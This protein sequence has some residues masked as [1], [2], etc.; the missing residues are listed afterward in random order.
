MGDRHVPRYEREN[1]GGAAG[2]KYQLD[3]EIVLSKDAGFFGDPRR[4][5]IGA[6]GAVA[7]I[8]AGSLSAG[9][10]TKRQVKRQRSD[11]YIKYLF[12]FYRRAP[13]D[14]FLAEFYRTK[15][16]ETRKP[17][18][19]EPG[20]SSRQTQLR[21]GIAASTYSAYFSARNCL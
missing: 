6:G 4:Q 20:L 5:L 21:D 12:H 9:K 11:H 1:G 19:K 15:G 14:F 7:D 3:I 2:E 17:G 8:E 16:V 18:S 10:R 13:S